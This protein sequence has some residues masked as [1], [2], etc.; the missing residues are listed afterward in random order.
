MVSGRSIKP[1]QSWEYSSAA[2]RPNPQICAWCG[3]GS[4]SEEAAATAPWVRHHRARATRVHRGP[5]RGPWWRPVPWGRPGDPGGWSSSRARRLSTPT[6]AFA[7]RRDGELLGEGLAMNSNGVEVSVW[8][9]APWASSAWAAAWTAGCSARPDGTR[10]NQVPV[11]AGA[12]RG[13]AGGPRRSGSATSRWWSAPGAVA[14]RPR[15]GGGPVA[16]HRCRGRPSPELQRAGESVHVLRFD[17][18]PQLRLGR[19]MLRAVAV[20]TADGRGEPEALV[21]EGVGGEFDGAWGW[22]WR[23]TRVPSRRRLR[24]CGVV[25]GCG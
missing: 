23:G 10:S 21:L 5:G 12:V 7:R 19:V 17:G 9:A 2:T 11:R 14:A 15:E 16:G 8:R 18:A 3:W 22:G 20:G 24:W 1:P 13:R 6:G 25:R 4:G